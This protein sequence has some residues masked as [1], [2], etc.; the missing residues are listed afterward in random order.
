MGLVVT[1]PPAIVEIV[2]SKDDPKYVYV[3]VN[4]CKIKID[5]RL[6][7]DEDKLVDK[8]MKICGE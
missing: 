8:I 7:K 6:L 1:T 2:D 3:T 4:K 5:K